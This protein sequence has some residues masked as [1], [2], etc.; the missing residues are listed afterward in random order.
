[1]GRIN[2]FHK[3]GET[4]SKRWAKMN[5]EDLEE[6]KKGIQSWIRHEKAHIDEFK[7]LIRESEELIKDY[8]Q[9]LKDIEKESKNND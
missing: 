1:M 9:D 8:K 5:S 7:E 4:E 3:D 2:Y 6:R